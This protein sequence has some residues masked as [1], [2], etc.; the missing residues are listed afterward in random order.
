MMVADMSGNQKVISPAN[1][2]RLHEADRRFKRRMMH[3]GT[4][5]VSQADQTTI[6]FEAPFSCLPTNSSTDSHFCRL[7]DSLC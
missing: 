5:S 6:S 1:T 4:Q 3:R 2:H 7:Q